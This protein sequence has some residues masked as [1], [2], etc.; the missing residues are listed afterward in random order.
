MTYTALQASTNS[1]SEE[2]PLPSP[3]GTDVAEWARWM[4]SQGHEVTE[5]D[6]SD[7]LA[8]AFQPE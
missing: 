4:K 1:S 3:V 7:D 6:Y 2:E 8:L 5:E